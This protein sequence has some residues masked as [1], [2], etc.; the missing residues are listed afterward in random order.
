M[1]KSLK[2]THGIR[3]RGLL[4]SAVGAATNVAMYDETANIYDVAAAYAY[5][6]ARTS[7][8]S[9]AT[10]APASR[11]RPRSTSPKGGGLIPPWARS[12]SGMSATLRE[13]F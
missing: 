2:G 12:C 8:S 6:V 11:R 1:V 7:P 9:T 5:H 10:S 3:A 13:Y 4:E